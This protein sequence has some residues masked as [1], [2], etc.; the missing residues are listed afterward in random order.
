MFELIA[1]WCAKQEA[2]FDHIYPYVTSHG[3]AVR[4]AWPHLVIQVRLCQSRRGLMMF[5]TLVML[6]LWT[7]LVLLKPMLNV[8]QGFINGT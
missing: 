4:G 3:H 8:E 6:L 5:R 1:A 2:A 7:Q